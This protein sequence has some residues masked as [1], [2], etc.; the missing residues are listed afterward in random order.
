MFK[1]GYLCWIIQ[2]RARN[3]S[4]ILVVSLITYRGGPW[5]DIAVSDRDLAQ[6]IGRFNNGTSHGFILKCR[7]SEDHLMYFIDRRQSEG[8]Q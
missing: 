5:A 8:E 7:S 2:G 3:N 4:R 6:A 1:R